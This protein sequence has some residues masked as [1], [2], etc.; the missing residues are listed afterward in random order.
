MVLKNQGIKYIRYT[1]EEQ[2][3]E[4]CLALKEAEVQF[5]LV[6]YLAR[7]VSGVNGDEIGGK[8]SPAARPLICIL[9]RS[10]Y[11]SPLLPAAGP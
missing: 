9:I 11:Q 7:L 1:Q 4:V 8:S 6:E 2:R 3:R 10:Q 5:K